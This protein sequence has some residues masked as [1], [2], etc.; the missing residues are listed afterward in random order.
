LRLIN[1]IFFA[2]LSES[3]AVSTKKIMVIDDNPDILEIVS[4]LLADEGYQV[5]T[6]NSG[7]TVIQEIQGFRPDLVLMDVMLAGMDGRVICS[8]I[9]QMEQTKS[10]P[11]ILISASHDLEASL[12]QQ[13]AP[14]DFIAKP[15]D[16]DVLLKK[17]ELQLAA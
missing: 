3:K 16:I 4:Y 9:K 10:L 14:N 5:A 13:G 17:V 12:D 8:N 11:V 7:E 2:G 1:G 15:F 6:L